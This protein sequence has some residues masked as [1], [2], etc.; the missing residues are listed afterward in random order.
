MAS[1]L[2]F[3]QERLFNFASINGN[4]AACVK[5]A[6]T[7][8]IY[9]SWDF[10]AQNDP[11]FL[12]AWIRNRHGAQQRLRV[13]MLRREA[14]LRACPDFH[15]FSQVHDTDA[16]GYVFDDGNRMRDKQIRQTELVLQ[17]RQEIDDLSLDRDIKRRN[18]LVGYDQFG[19]QGQRPRDT[20]SLPLSAAELMRIT[21][22]HGRIQTHRLQEIRNAMLAVETAGES[23]NGEGLANNGPDGHAGVQGSVWILKDNLHIA[24]F[25][26]QL[27][28]AQLQKIH[29]IEPYS[30]GVRL[31]QAQDGPAGGRF[32][33]TGFADQP[34]CLAFIDV[35][36]NVVDSFDVRRGTR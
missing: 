10:S 17:V 6:S 14:N 34:E 31:D 2:D 30:S 18:G 9:W 12:S 20:D 24:P 13:R 19:L 11:L 26:A 27:L 8:R 22:H 3:P 15:E 36:T 5:P 35:K 23:M 25:A 1:L 16:R 4:R 21:A 29:A 33:T 28:F 32:S 7:R